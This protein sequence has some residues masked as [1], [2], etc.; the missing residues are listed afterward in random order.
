MVYLKIGKNLCEAIS[1]M[2][3]NVGRNMVRKT[4]YVLLGNLDV[5][6][7]VHKARNGFMQ[8]SDKSYLQ[9]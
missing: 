8:G 4:F 3:V 1:K 9:F 6:I 7:W 2:S 5:I